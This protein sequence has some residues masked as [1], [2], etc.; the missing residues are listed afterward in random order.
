[1]IGELEWKKIFSWVGF[2]LFVGV[3]FFHFVS[4]SAYVLWGLMKKS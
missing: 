4:F 3:N 1:M 2:F